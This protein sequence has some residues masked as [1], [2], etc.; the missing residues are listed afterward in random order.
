MKNKALLIAATSLLFV[1]SCKKDDNP[2]TTV[3]FE[4]AKTNAIKNFTNNIAVG[5]Y[6]DLNNAAIKLNTSILA[7]NSSAT[8]AN[9]A[10]ARTDWKNMR[11]IWEQSEGFLFGPVADND[12]DPKMDTWPTD[13]NE[14]ETLLASSDPLTVSSIEAKPLT[15]RG[16]HP[17]EYILF[18]TDGNRA[19]TSI[20][21]RQKTYMVSLSADLKNTCE[22]LYTAWTGSANYASEVLNAG[23]TSTVYKTKKELFIALVDG[24]AGICEEVGGGKIF[25]PYT[26]KDSSIV[27]SPYSGTSMIDFRNNIIGLQNVYLGRY[28]SKEGTGITDVV[29]AKNKSL[30]NKIQGQI[31]AAIA[32]INNVTVPF[33]LAIFDQRVQTKAAMD[34]LATLQKTLEDEL[35]PFVVQYITD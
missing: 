23:G 8:E 16:Y 5:T 35:N 19:A 15:L 2:A 24:M 32:A 17:I 10:T 30:D 31:A 29:A 20:T 18:G 11:A 34:A 25:E 33:E 4:T 28:G 7:L 13:F 26:A 12:Y 21:A 1:A 22:A 9:L 6:S 14:M 3:D 27:E